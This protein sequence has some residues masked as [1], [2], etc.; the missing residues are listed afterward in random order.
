MKKGAASKTTDVDGV[1][2]ATLTSV[3][4]GSMVN[5]GL[6]IYKNFILSKTPALLDNMA[7]EADSSAAAVSEEE[8]ENTSNN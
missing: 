2:G 4:V 6:K 5:E 3:G 8:G 1:T 7:V